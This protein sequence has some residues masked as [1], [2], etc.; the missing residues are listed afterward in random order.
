MEIDGI[1]RN[2]CASWTPE[3]SVVTLEC[4]RRRGHALV[5][6]CR[7]WIVLIVS[8][9]GGSPHALA[10]SVKRRFSFFL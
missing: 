9:N 8:D 2:L 5:L 3:I 1:F 4:C 7:V 6:H 10:I